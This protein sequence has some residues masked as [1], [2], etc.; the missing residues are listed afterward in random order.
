MDMYKVKWTRLQSEILRLFCI[1]SA[2]S[3]NMREIARAIGVTPT[4]VAQEIRELEKNGF[5]TIQKQK[6][7]NL[8]AVTFKRDNPKA[9]EFKRAE[10]LRMLYESGLAEFLHNE[11]PGCTVV[12]FG[13]Y[14]RGD[15]AYT[16]NQE[17]RSDMDIAVIGTK[18]KD[19]SLTKFDKLLERKISINFYDSF[20]N[21]HKHLRD[22]ILNGI[23]LSGGIEI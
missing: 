21:I 14:S 4:A 15:D 1:K 5:I 9:I 6:N 22:N 19:I 2:M 3:L 23:V 11:F 16:E 8:V 7:I 20:K 18:G 12:L 10:N 17:N 13:S